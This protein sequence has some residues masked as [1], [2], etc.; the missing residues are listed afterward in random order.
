MK[1]WL[2]SEF[3]CRLHEWGCL[4]IREEVSLYFK[5]TFLCCEA[6][7]SLLLVAAAKPDA[8]WENSLRLPAS[9]WE[10]LVCCSMWI[11]PVLPH[12]QHL[13]EKQRAA[14]RKMSRATP[15]P[16]KPPSS[17]CSH[18]PRGNG[19]TEPPASRAPSQQ[20]WSWLRTGIAQTLLLKQ[21]LPE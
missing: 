3:L 19:A 2:L 5:Y 17:C 4:V 9:G 15:R 10:P 8:V 7:L 20:V 16:A 11:S 21:R 18:P 13:R 6:N 1:N 12:K 14:C